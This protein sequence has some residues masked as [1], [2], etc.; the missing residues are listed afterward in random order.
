MCGV[1]FYVVWRLVLL[2]RSVPHVAADADVTD[3]EP[4]QRFGFSPKIRNESLN[5]FWFLL[6]ET[7]GSD[8]KF[9][10]LSGKV[11][12]KEPVFISIKISFAEVQVVFPVLS[13]QLFLIKFCVCSQ[14]H[15]EDGRW[16]RPAGLLQEPHQPGSDEDAARP[17]ETL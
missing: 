8:E 4:Q 10:K 7:R 1:T 5:R 12:L 17:G 16:R 11:K 2:G 6:S 13:L 15:S 3:E 14:H 9:C